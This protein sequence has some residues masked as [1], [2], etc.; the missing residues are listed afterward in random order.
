MLSSVLEK[1]KTRD[2]LGKRKDVPWTAVQT[3]REN[4][5]LV[6]AKPIFRH[7]RACAGWDRAMVKHITAVMGWYVWPV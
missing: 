1:R 6:E 4:G 2:R 7:D 5:N 3:A